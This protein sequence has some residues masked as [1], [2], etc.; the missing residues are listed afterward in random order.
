MKNR[1]GIISLTSLLCLLAALGVHADVV[2]FWTFDDINYGNTT[3]QD[4]GFSDLSGHN[5]R[6]S[7]GAPFSTPQIVPGVSGGS[8]DTAVSF[9]GRGGLYIDDSAAQSLNLQPPFTVQAWVRSDVEQTGN[10]GIVTYGIPGGRT[11]G[12]GWKMGLNGGNI[13][14]TLYAV[15]DLDSSAPFPFDGQWHHI[16]VPYDWSIVTYYID[17]AELDAR[18][19]SRAVANP[20]ANDMN[21]GLEFN[22]I[23]R[24]TGDID[25]VRVS[26]VF[27]EAD[28]LDTDA[29]NPKPIDANTL[30][31]FNFDEGALPFTSQGAASPALTAISSQ[32]WALNG[33]IPR[34]N[35]LLPTIEENSPTGATGDSSLF[36]DLDSGTRAFIADG[37]GTLDFGPG[38]DWTVEAWV[39][40]DL[41][42]TE[43]EII[44]YYGRPG[45]GYSLSI[46]PDGKLQV[47][48]LGI[49]DL[50]STNAIVHNN[51]E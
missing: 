49:A 31:Y 1:I 3:P 25:R 5:L 44:F 40:T 50:S 8:S 26:N 14:F 9:D 4:A 20:G 36:F 41:S 46:N 23:S 48:T 38:Q 6:G 42:Y 37:N 45:F 51:Y 21:M 10:Y 32:E 12:G 35:I 18:A 24:F 11:G 19:E 28:A 22:A 7:I 15:V 34:N 27:L 29:A 33:N 17:G 2:G 13:R 16:A 47:T 30:A 39:S 43:R